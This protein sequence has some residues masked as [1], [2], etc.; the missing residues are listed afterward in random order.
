ME[1]ILQY[2]THTFKK[3]KYVKVIMKVLDTFYFFSFNV[4]DQ[5]NIKMALSWSD[6]NPNH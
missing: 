3:M 4:D 2:L 1:I 6:I 5:V